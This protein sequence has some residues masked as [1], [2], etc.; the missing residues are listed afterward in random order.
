M[1]TIPIIPFSEGEAV[2]DWI[3]LTDALAAGHLLPKA[4]IADTFLYRDPDTLLNRA[5]WIDGLGLAVKSATIFPG[6][7]AQGLSSVNGGV[8]LYC[9]KTGTLEAIVDFHLVTKWKT[10]G[11]SLLAARRLAR[12]DSRTILIVG[13]GTQARALHSAYSALFPDAQFTVWNR[14]AQNAEQL[15]REIPSIAIA[16]DLETAV[17][18]ADIV[19]AAT[20]TTTPLIRGAWLQ[21]G[22]HI[23]LIG[24]YRPD[25]RE[26]DDDA[27]QRARVFVDSLD[28]TVDHIGELKIPIAAGAFSADQIVADYYAPESFKR[29]SDD[30]ITLF[31][32]GGGAHLDLMTSRFILERWQA[33][34]A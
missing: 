10:A 20:M 1:T 27:L 6:N 32:N 31:K 29:Q 34:A 15:A 25:M 22:Q 13:A 18:A 33:Q 19:T 14:T 12:A 26:V 16:E 24:A 17:R 8:T 7:T 4:E 28:T 11:D 21:P 5:A 3:G 2:L 9:D 30:E 23:D